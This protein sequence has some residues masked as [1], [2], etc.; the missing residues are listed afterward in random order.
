MYIY[1]NVYVQQPQ[2]KNIYPTKKRHYSIIKWLHI[3]FHNYWFDY[4]IILIVTSIQYGTPYHHAIPNLTKKI[5]THSFGKVNG[6]IFHLQNTCIIMHILVPIFIN[7]I[8]TNI[9][10]NLFNLYQIWIVIT[11]LRL[12]L[13]Q[14]EFRLEPDESEKCNYN[15]NLVWI[16]S[17]LRRIACASLRVSSSPYKEIFSKSY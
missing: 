4:T 7:C 16:I 1:L 2:N 3:Y 9:L 8:Q 17:N 14:T 10:P 13:H 11:L 5:N 15:P 6:F 12:I